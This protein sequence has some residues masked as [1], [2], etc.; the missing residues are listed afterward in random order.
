[1]DPELETVPVIVPDPESADS[2]NRKNWDV[3]TMGEESRTTDALG[4]ECQDLRM[5]EDPA[6]RKVPLLYTLAWITTPDVLERSKK[7]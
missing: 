1:M 6:I 2:G 7:R 4:P 3:C 5:S